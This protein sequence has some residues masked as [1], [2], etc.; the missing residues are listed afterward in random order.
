MDD[1]ND[2]S[3]QFTKSEYTAGVATDA[4]VGSELIRVLAVDADV[5]NNSLVLYSILG[6]RYIKQHSNDSEEVANIFSIGTLDGILRTFDLFTAYNPGYFV[7]DIMASDLVGHNDTA[8]VGI[9]ILRDDQ[10]VKI[11]INEIPD[12]VRQFEEEFI[13]LLSNITGA[14]VN[15]D[16]VQF[17][18][19]KK[20]RVNFAQTELLIHVVNRE[21]NRIL[22][23]ERVIQMI[24]ENKEQLRNLFR[25]YNVL[26]VQPAITAHAPD[27]LSALQM[28]IIVLAVL[29]F[30]AAMLF[31]LMNW[32]KRKLKAIVAGS[33]GEQCWGF[34][35]AWLSRVPGWHAWC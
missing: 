7:V 6:I 23:V 11:I 8:I 31:I 22:D 9:Y 29:L 35:A 1:I 28:A 33:T 21:T 30:L 16:D 20:G 26:D 10:R 5:G 13:S 19:D 32:H 14:I 15:T 34:P 27:D 4:K 25:N 3:P 12:K 24:D 18:V 2:Q 17:H